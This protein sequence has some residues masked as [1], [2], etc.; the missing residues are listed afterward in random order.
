MCRRTSSQPLHDQKSS[1]QQMEDTHVWTRR[2]WQTVPWREQWALHQWG[3]ILVSLEMPSGSCNAQQMS[4]SCRWKSCMI[5]WR[6]AELSC[7][8]HH[9]M[10]SMSLVPCDMMH[11]C[12]SELMNDLGNSTG[13]D[14]GGHIW[15]L[16]QMQAC[17]CSH[18]SLYH[19]QGLSHPLGKCP[20]GQKME[21]AMLSLEEGS[22]QDSM[23]TLHFSHPR[24]V[25]LEL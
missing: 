13:K 10:T 6:R 21:Q 5:C 24:A 12:N 11:P 9:P 19:S 4:G 16:T 14:G 7:S 1:P 23:G 22:I 17:W 15:Q 2:R 8:M 18:Y 3:S 20:H 25:A